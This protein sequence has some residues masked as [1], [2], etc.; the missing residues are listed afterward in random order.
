MCVAGSKVKAEVM[1]SGCNFARLSW[2]HPFRERNHLRQF[3][4]ESSATLHA[5]GDRQ[6]LVI[7]EITDGLSVLAIRT[8]VSY[9]LEMLHNILLASG[10]FAA[11]DVFVSQ[12]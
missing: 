7:H 9:F 12:K 10:L 5:A 1:R 6:Y 4:P 3:N 2:E 8:G 11:I